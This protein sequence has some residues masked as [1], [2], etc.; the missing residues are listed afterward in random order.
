ML[1]KVQKQGRNENM[2]E[3]YQVLYYRT[4]EEKK[5]KKTTLHLAVY[6]ANAG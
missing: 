6:A 3:D 1:Q 4:V 2:Q 5:G